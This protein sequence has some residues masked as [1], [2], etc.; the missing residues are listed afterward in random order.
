[1]A[2][3]D[4]NKVNPRAIYQSRLAA[5]EADGAACQRQHLLLGYARLALVV[6]GIAVSWFSF[7]QH[8]VSRWWLLAIF[9]VFVVVARRH[10]GVLQQKAEAQRATSFF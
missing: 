1:M 9:A 7:Y 5:R 2:M 3:N 4:S 6:A 8:L 10:S